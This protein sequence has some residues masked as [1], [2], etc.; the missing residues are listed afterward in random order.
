[1]K[2]LT[3]NNFELAKKNINKEVS[4]IFTIE[5]ILYYDEFKKIAYSFIRGVILE[6]DDEFLYFDIEIPDWNNS[7]EKVSFLLGKLP[8]IGNNEWEGSTLNSKHPYGSTSI[9]KNLLQDYE[10]RLLTNLK[11]VINNNSLIG[12]SFEFDYYDKL[13]LIHREHNIKSGANRTLGQISIES[14][15]NQK[16]LEMDI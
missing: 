2:T 8:K 13:Y 1:L 4:K 16:F 7:V 3:I 11:K 5:D 14:F 12:V 15:I 9:S 10:K 6:F